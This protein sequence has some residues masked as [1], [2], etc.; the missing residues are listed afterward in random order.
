MTVSDTPFKKKRVF[1][2]PKKTQIY[3]ICKKKKK[4]FKYKDGKKQMNRTIN[5]QTLIES[6]LEW[7]NQTKTS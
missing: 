1:R 2:L 4:H 5:M 7:I 6:K 3:A